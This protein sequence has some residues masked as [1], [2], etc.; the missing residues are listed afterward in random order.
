MKTITLRVSQEIHAALNSASPEFMEGVDEC[1]GEGRVIGFF[2][3]YC[4]PIPAEPIQMPEIFFNNNY[5]Q[6]CMGVAESLNKNGIIDADELATVAKAI[7]L[8]R[9]NTVHRPLAAGFNKEDLAATTGLTNCD[10]SR[11]AAVFDLVVKAN[12]EFAEQSGVA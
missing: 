8:R 2:Q 5:Y 3:G 10:Q 7:W 4:F 11:M 1:T 9:Y 6:L 12:L